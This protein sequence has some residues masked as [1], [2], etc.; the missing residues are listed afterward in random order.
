M[1]AFGK[2]NCDI[3]LAAN[4]ATKDLL[5][6]SGLFLSLPKVFRKALYSEHQFLQTSLFGGFSEHRR[7]GGEFA[8]QM[9]SG[10]TA[11]KLKHLADMEWSARAEL[12]LRQ[13]AIECYL[14]TEQNSLI[15]NPHKRLIQL[16]VTS[17]LPQTPDM[18]P[19][20]N[21]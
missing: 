4:R 21:N 7:H 13:K 17:D 1:R 20:R 15:N 3:G 6:T 12:K 14:P 9:W 8:R 16:A 2:G 18:S 19:R 10:Q 11:E 5:K